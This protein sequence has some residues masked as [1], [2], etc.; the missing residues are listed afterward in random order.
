M[1]QV[2]PRL[3]RRTHRPPRPVERTGDG[4]TGGGDVRDIAS[5][6]A[7]RRGVR[8]NEDRREGR[9]AR[10]VRRAGIRSGVSARRKRRRPALSLG[11]SSASSRRLSRA[12]PARVGRGGIQQLRQRERGGVLGPRVGVALCIERHHVDHHVELGGELRSRH[13][14]VRVVPVSG[15]SAL[16]GAL[17]SGRRCARGMGDGALHAIHKAGVE[18]PP[19]G[20]RIR[21]AARGWVL[22]FTC[23]PRW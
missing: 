20:V 17:R 10:G 2:R 9:D 1:A 14:L 13:E 23:Q 18:V 21:R 19:S 11:L 6:Y 3:A 12:R 16:V 22:Y 15:R 5:T 4:R 7:R 8:R